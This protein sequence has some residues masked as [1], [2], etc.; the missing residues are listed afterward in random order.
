MRMLELAALIVFI[1]IASFVLANL[2]TLIPLGLP[3]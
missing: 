3:G 2:P 1:L